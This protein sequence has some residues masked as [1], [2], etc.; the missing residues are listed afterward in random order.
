VL[1]YLAQMEVKKGVHPSRWRSEPM[2]IECMCVDAVQ[3][4]ADEKSQSVR[5]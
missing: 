3:R 1:S 5:D 2:G 4:S